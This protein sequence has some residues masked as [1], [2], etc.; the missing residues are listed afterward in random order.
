MK[1][2]KF[3]SDFY[4]SYDVYYRQVERSTKNKIWRNIYVEYK[5][6]GNRKQVNSMAD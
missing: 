1:M 3:I 5:H 6:N 2:S 4:R